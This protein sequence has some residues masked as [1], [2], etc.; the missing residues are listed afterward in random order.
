MGGADNQKRHTL[1]KG[2]D[3]NPFAR[4]SSQALGITGTRMY[5]P[6]HFEESRRSALHTLIRAHP[7][8]TLVTQSPAGINAEH[9][10]LLLLD[11]EERNGILQGHVARANPLWENISNGSEV[12]AIFQGPNRYISPKWYPSKKEHGKVVPT[13]N[14]LVV[15]ARGNIRWTQ[16][17]SWLRAHLDAA[18]R[19]H[20]G[21]DRPWRVSDAPSDFI[22]R[23][24]AA[25]VGFELTISE[26]RGKWKLSQNR[27]EEDRLG[28]IAGLKNESTTL[29]TE[30]L[31]WMR[32]DSG[33][34]A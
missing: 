6:S 24:L 33:G 9:I 28:V 8:A 1:C 25:I 23:M 22:Q 27:S 16:D 26:L 7:L 4:S 19:T 31:S 3:C 32:G 11:S 13:W 14:Y 10:P 15:H 18:T 12:L 5:T 30:M 20:E 34:D 29:A 17:P 2:N 21:S